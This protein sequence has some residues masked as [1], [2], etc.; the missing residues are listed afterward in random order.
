[1]NA[2]QPDD[3]VRQW[4]DVA[5][6]VGAC[7]AANRDGMVE[8]SPDSLVW[9]LAWEQQHHGPNDPQNEERGRDFWRRVEERVAAGG[10]PARTILA[11]GIVRYGL[12]AGSNMALYVAARLAGAIRV[13]KGHPKGTRKKNRAPDAQLQREYRVE[14]PRLKQ[15]KK[16]NRRAFYKAAGPEKPSDA[17]IHVVATRHS[18]SFAVAK[19]AIHPPRNGRK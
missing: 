19:R 7:Y 4:G 11:I 10:N 15:L 17:A 1:M 13:R 3:S 18:I 14:L 12:P 5:A 6:H 16:E 8:Y 2:P 9:K